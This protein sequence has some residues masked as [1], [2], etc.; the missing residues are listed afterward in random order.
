MEVSYKKVDEV[1]MEVTETLDP[2]VTIITVDELKNR[3]E[4]FESQLQQLESQKIVLLGQIKSVSDAL[5]EANKIGIKSSIQLAQEPVVA[6]VGETNEED[7]N[8]Q[9]KK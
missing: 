4:A 7:G 6:E 3:K 2:M 8:I 5:L 1:S 9:G